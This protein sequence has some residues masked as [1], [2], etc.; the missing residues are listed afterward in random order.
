MKAH[1]VRITCFSILLILGLAL[2][3]C[4]RPTSDASPT[5]NVT[6]AYQT[7]EVLLTDSVGQTPTVTTAPETEIPTTES[8][9][10]GTTSEPASNT[11]TPG[12]EETS[13]PAQ[14]CNQAAAAFPK[15]DITIDDDTEMAPGETFTKIWRVVN[16]GTCTW[17]N[18]Y[19]VVYFSGEKLAASDW[20][21]LERV[22]APNESI[23]IAVDM[24]S[25]SEPGEYQSNWK[26]S[27]DDSKLFGIGPGGESPFWVRIIVVQVETPTPTASPQPTETPVVA[28]SGPAVLAADD[29]ID[30]DSN[31]VNG[32]TVDLTFSMTP[33]DDPLYEL[34]PQGSTSLAV[35][36]AGQPSLSDCQNAAL[37]A[38]PLNMADLSDTYICYET[39]MGLPGWLL[40]DSLDT[41]GPSVSIQMLTWS[42]P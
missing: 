11:E 14:A 13:E 37:T 6:Q 34:V 8:G 12:V 15:I 9:E 4:N 2:T 27:T 28:A 29:T 30:L 38:A 42:L 21:P 22:V 40:I 19:A 1:A 10:P 41:E 36:G 26:L 18:G 7:V 5:M 33:G 39:N 16:I 24:T 32:G 3:G 25:P 35:F 31:Q 20:I 23:D 17:G